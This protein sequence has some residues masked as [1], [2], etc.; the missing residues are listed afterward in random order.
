MPTIITAAQLRSTLGVST[1]LYSDAVLDDIID[2]AEQ[3]VIPLLVSYASPIIAHQRLTNVATIFTAGAHNFIIG[4]SVVVATPHSDFNG[5]K[6]V[7]EVPTEDSFSYSSTGTDVLKNAIIPSGTATITGASTYV[8]VSAIESAI[9]VVSVEVFQSR[10]APGGQI[11]GVD[12]SPT[13]Y[14]MGR[15]LYS[16]VAGLLGPYIDV[17]SIAQ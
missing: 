17:A 13:P 2:T 5:T 11:E 7:T 16:R 15:S 1:S 12:F 4:S 10:T 9:L 6:T 8:G 3:V 14:R